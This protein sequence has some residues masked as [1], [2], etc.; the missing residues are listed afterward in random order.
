MQE[1]GT[2]K[3]GEIRFNFN[4][5][6]NVSNFVRNNEMSSDY[7]IMSSQSFYQAVLFKLG[8]NHEE[9]ENVEILIFGLNSNEGQVDEK[10]SDDYMKF[11]SF[12]LGNMFVNFGARLK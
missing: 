3:Y 4:L 10:I 8:I 9:K 6:H 7:F 12:P 1:L 2:I 11:E 5:S